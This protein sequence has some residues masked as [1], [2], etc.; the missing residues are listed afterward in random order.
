MN[1]S[2]PVG[3]VRALWRFPVKSMLGEQLDVVEVGDGQSGH[4][5]LGGGGRSVGARAPYHTHRDYAVGGRRVP[6]PTPSARAHVLP[7][8]R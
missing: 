5:T 7:D 3:T 4:C 8:Q 2:D 1:S 6:S